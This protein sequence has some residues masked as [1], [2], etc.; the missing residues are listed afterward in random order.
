MAFGEH[1][2]DHTGQMEIPGRDP[3]R[4]VR[5]QLD[6]ERAPLEPEIRMVV[7]AFGEITDALHQPEPRSI[8]RERD[9]ADQTIALAP[10]LPAEPS[11]AFGD[12]LVLQLHAGR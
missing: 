5:G 3:A 12:R 8:A 7:R 4:V 1:V 9:V 6:A 10:P 11:D 2:L